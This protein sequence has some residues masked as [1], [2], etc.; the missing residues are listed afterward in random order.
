MKVRPGTVQ[1]AYVHGERDTHSFTDSLNGLCLYDLSHNARLYGGS[2]PIKVRYGTDGLP[3]ARNMAVK[4]FLEDDY[5]WML[6]ID[7]DMGFE[8][9]AV[10]QLIEVADPIT[11]PIVGA[12]CFAQREIDID[13]YS[14]FVTRAGVTIMDWR[15]GPN[16]WGFSGRA[17]YQPNAMTRCDAT[18]SAFLLIHRTVFEKIA[19][20]NGQVWYDKVRSEDG[21]SVSEDLSFCMRAAVVEC[22]I[23]V[24]TGVRTT[25][26]KT[27]WLSESDFWEQQVSPPATEQTAVLVPVMKRPKSAERFMKTLRASTG[28]ATVYAIYDEADEV[29]RDAWKLA[30]AETLLAS[31]SSF[32]TKINDG[33]RATNEPWLFIVGD[34]VAFFPGWLDHAQYAAVITGAD[35]VGT[36]DCGNPRVQRGEHATH[37]LIR[38][39]YVDTVGASWDGPGVVCHEGYRHWHTDDEI[40]YAAKQRQTWS[41][42]LAS[43][44]EHLHPYWNKGEYD[45]T[46]RIG[47]L[48]AERDRKRFEKRLKEFEGA[49]CV[50]S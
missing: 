11:A 4:R 3:G 8:P 33:Y 34:D 43:R 9:T 10:D 44:V 26:M 29:T 50:S 2:G 38:R 40:V 28:L 16:G 5:E 7:T 19:A 21:A 6:W 15:E 42:A 20:E 49:S 22:P 37:L 24:H 1:L 31:G 45:E 46:Y 25:H 14:G 36:N 47:E 18:G 13:G 35:V 12:V 23:W 17:W 41:M 30:G 27:L 48:Y 39:S 32:P